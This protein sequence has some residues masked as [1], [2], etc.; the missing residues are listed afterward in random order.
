MKTFKINF[1]GRKTGSIGISYHI[2]ETVNAET[3]ELAIS[4]L[5]DRYENIHMLRIET[6][7]NKRS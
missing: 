6:L 3:K 4:S 1:I 5:Y 7:S 2:F